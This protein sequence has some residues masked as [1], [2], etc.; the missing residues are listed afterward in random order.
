MIN[1]RFFKPSYRKFAPMHRPKTYFSTLAL[2]NKYYAI[3][4]SKAFK[5][6]ADALD[7]AHKFHNRWCRLYDAAI[8]AT[9]VAEE[10]ASSLQTVEV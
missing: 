4:T 2:Q 8:V 3:K 9:G 6:A 1:P 7:Y 5:R 10:P